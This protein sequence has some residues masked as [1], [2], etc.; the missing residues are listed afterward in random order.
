MS[1]IMVRRVSKMRPLNSIG[2]R[3]QGSTCHMEHN[4]YLDGV[5]QLEM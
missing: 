3:N 2:R 4:K 5:A 1:P